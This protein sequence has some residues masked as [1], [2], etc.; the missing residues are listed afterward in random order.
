MALLR[1]GKAERA[2]TELHLCLAAEPNNK[3]A[4]Y[5]IQQI[6]APLDQLFP[7]SNFRVKLARNQN[8][9]FLAK[10][11]LGNPLAFYGLAR[12]N[13]IAA[14]SKVYEGQIIRVPKTATAVAAQKAQ[15]K[16]P[17]RTGDT[18]L[19]REEAALPP[20]PASADAAKAPLNT[21]KPA[22]SDGKSHKEAARYYHVGLV[23]FEQ[24][25]L[26]RAIT[27]WKKALAADPN[28]VEAQVSLAQAQRLKQNLRE[29][30][31]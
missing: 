17:L 6:E 15:T 22:A 8:L 11:Y 1:D 12:Y 27:A 16:A 9:S 29:L 14:P 25:D 28:Y 13:G 2:D 10:I 7:R 26:D 19:S 18:S 3:A 24:Q 5:L 21:A 20:A 4:Q 30:R 23:A 31:K